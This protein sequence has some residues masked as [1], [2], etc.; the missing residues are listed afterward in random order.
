MLITPQWKQKAEILLFTFN[1]R[2]VEV[3]TVHLDK[4]V[5]RACSALCAPNLC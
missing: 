3:G 2:E 5:E 1:V 4:L